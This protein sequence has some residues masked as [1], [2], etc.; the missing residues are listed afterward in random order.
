MATVAE[1]VKVVSV[2]TGEPE[3]FVSQIARNLLIS[4]IL[5][6]NVGKRY[7]RV[8]ETNLTM[9]LLGLYTAPKIAD[10]SQRARQYAE[11]PLDGEHAGIGLADFLA[12]VLSDLH[13]RDDRLVRIIPGVVVPYDELRIEIIATYPVV[14]VWRVE[15]VGEASLERSITSFAETPALARYWPSPKPRRSVTIPGAALFAIVSGVFGTAPN[16]E[17]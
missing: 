7:S 16:P 2:E 15:L 14:I 13:T 8:S 10:A 12:T 3:P 5:P 1:A 4:G 17:T 11:L 6:K 9:L